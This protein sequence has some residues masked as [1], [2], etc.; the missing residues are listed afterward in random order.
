M[1]GPEMT[2][3]GWIEIGEQTF[4]DLLWMHVPSHQS[5]QVFELPRKNYEGPVWAEPADPD[6]I[7]YVVCSRTHDDDGNPI[8]CEGF[9]IESYGRALKFAR[10]TRNRIHSAQQPKAGLQL[11]FDDALA[12]GGG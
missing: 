2:A 7:G 8:L 6:A 3:E 1:L 12:R 9:W 10:E 4:T 11:T 5:V